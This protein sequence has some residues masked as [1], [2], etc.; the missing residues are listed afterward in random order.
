MVRYLTKIFCFLIIWGLSIYPQTTNDITQ[1]NKELEKIREEIFQLQEELK[2][3]SLEEK[4]SL[5]TLENLT[6]QNLLIN[7]LIK[8]LE[9]QSRQKAIDISLTEKKLD[10]IEKKINLLKEKYANYIVWVYKNRRASTLRYL[11]NSNSFTQTLKRYQYLKYISS[12]NEK[13]LNRLQTESHDLTEIINQLEREKKEKEELVSKTVNEQNVLIEKQK[14]RRDLIASLKKDQKNITTEIEQKRRAEIQIKNIIARLVEE[15]R[16]RKSKLLEAK[17]KEKNEIPTYNYGSLQNFAELRG[18]MNWPVQ[19]GQIVRK[20]GENK[21]ER[22]KTVTLNYGIDIKINDNQ[23]VYS[24]AEGYVSAIDW[25]PGY[26][27][28]I[29]ITHRDEY[30]TVY[31]HVA[32]IIVKEGQK[33]SAGDIIGR[34]SDSLEGTILHFEIWYER[35]YQN[36]EVWLVRR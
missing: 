2:N 34:V 15:E 3:K 31:G 22:L 33:V 13:T 11:V 9:T 18:I 4:E 36:P 28:I 8:N 7:R 26:G 19:G 12:S 29:I 21:N 27:S 30:R 25:I 32:D 24:V 23:N 5:T 20:F 14:Q 17:P 1:R 35:N 6:R 10:D 16:V